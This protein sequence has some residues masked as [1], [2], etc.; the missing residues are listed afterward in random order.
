[1]ND[2]QIQRTFEL[3]VV[4][5]MYT[6]VVFNELFRDLETVLRDAVPLDR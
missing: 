4:E 5:Y 6:R 3:S 1:M 2:R